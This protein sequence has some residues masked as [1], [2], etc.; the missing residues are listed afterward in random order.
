MPRQKQSK[1]HCAFCNRELTKAGLSKHLASCPARQQAI[2]SVEHRV[3]TET[4]YHVQAQ[5]AWQSQFWLHLEINGS[6]QLLDLDEYLRAIWLECCGHLSEFFIGKAYEGEL[7]Q[8]QKVDKVL[9]PGM[10]LTH[11]YD[12]GTSSETLI[13]VVGVRKGKPLSQH[14]VFL[15]ARNNPPEYPCMQCVQTASYLCM[16]CV[17]ELDET[18]TLCD[19]HI[20]THPHQDNYGDP[21]PLVNSPRLGMCGYDGPAEPPY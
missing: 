6:A 11:I 13:K 15:M 9:R 18:G 17:Y 5:D 4:I 16:E 3:K 1:G 14:P 19:Q 2:E 7:S 10:T 8:S 12:F 20:K 21:I